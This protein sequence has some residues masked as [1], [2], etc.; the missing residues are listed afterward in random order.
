MLIHPTAIIDK[1][2]DISEDVTIDAYTII[3]GKVKIGK[4]CKIHSHVV[5]EGDTEIGENNIIFQF[6]SI[7]GNPQDLKY[8]GGETKLTIGRDNV[9]REF[10]TINRG[11]EDGLGYTKIGNN[12]YIMAYSHIAHD[13]ILED[14]IILANNATLAGHI[15]VSKGAII[16]G[17]SAVHQF[18]RIGKF[19]M[20]AGK[21]GVVKDVPPFMLASGSRAELI[22]PNVVGLKRRGFDSE[23]L[24][25]IRKIYKILFTR[26]YNFS[27][28]VDIVK[29]QF[30]DSEDAKILLEF[31]Q[32]KSK[33]G[34]TL[35]KKSKVSSSGDICSSEEAI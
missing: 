29:N 16:G 33:R 32:S 5:I 14:E 21:T 34:I 27:E 26:R 13:C 30:K 18:S 10:V 3:K 4:G 23:R 31:V 19:A 12:N 28:A 8:K 24:S 9:F 17:L 15:T 7:G 11:T 20:V 1:C 2:A 25:N 35:G 22:G 6:G